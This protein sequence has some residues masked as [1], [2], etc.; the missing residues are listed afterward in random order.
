[1]IF[2]Y[3]RIPEKFVRLIL[4]D[5]F[6]VVH[7]PLVRIVKIQFLAQFPEDHLLH[8]VM[9]SLVLFLRLIDIFVYYVI[10]RFVS[11]TI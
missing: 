5:G 7:T 4:L 6:R 3:L 10:D 9:S 2:L 1:M 8:S 11:I